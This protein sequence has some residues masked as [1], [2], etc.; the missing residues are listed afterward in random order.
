MPCLSRTRDQRNIYEVIHFMCKVLKYSFEDIMTSVIHN[1]IM[2]SQ[3]PGQSGLGVRC[4]TYPSLKD[5]IRSSDVHVSI[6]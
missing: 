6:P 1:G 2:R 5:G 3:Y 4:F